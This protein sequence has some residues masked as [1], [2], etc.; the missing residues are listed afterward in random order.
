MKKTLSAKVKSTIIYLVT[1]G[2]SPSDIRAYLP[3][4]TP[5]AA[6]D[7]ARN[8]RPNRDVKA[9][10]TRKAKYKQTLYSVHVDWPTDG[11]RLTI[12]YPM[13][14]EAHQI[15]PHQKPSRGSIPVYNKRKLAERMA[16]VV[17]GKV[18]RLKRL[19]LS[20]YDSAAVA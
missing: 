7:Y 5:A 3:P 17:S 1:K 20:E 18:V 2:V 12:A 9:E 8:V 10:K 15:T 11:P 19:P 16:E 4:K 14:G 6:V 13:G